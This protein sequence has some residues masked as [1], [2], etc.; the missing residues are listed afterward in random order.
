MSCRLFFAGKLLV[1]CVREQCSHNDVP[2]P[3]SKPKDGDVV[4]KRHSAWGKT[5]E[6]GE[7]E[8]VNQMPSTHTWIET[9]KLSTGRASTGFERDL[10]SSSLF[11]LALMAITA[12]TA[13]PSCSP[14]YFCCFFTEQSSQKV[15]SC[16]GP[17]PP[18]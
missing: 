13:S 16:L 10:K 1:A 6:T 9:L 3:P 14:G 2:T 18:G 17:Q 11:F 4:R 12:E 7:E 15:K 5:Q 8:R